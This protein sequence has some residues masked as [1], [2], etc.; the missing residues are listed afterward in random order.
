M[1]YETVIGIIGKTHGVSSEIAPNV[2][3]SQMNDQRSVGCWFVVRSWLFVLSAIGCELRADFLTSSSPAKLTRFVRGGRQNVSL[4]SWNR[5]S[6][7]RYLGSGS[8]L[9]ART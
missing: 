8:S 7:A 6:N 3:A 1:K 5:T 9:R 2:A 4:Q